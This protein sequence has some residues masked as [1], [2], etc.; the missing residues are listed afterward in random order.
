VIS[1]LPVVERPT[2]VVV[3]VLALIAARVAVFWQRR[4]R[5]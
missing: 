4:R 3:G 5:G 2:W 1:D